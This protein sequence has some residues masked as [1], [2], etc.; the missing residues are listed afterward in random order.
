MQVC[1]LRK[2]FAVA[3]FTFA[4]LP[5]FSQAT[6]A[7]KHLFF[8]VQ[9]PKDHAPA[10]GRLL[11]FIENADMARKEAGPDGKVTEVETSPFHTEGA[12]VAAREVSYLAP[13][14]AVDIDTDDTVFP[15]GFSKLPAGDYVVQVLLDVNH[16]FDYNGRN[17]GD[18]FS[19]VANIHMDASMTDGPTL[20]LSQ[21]I[22][23]QVPWTLH[24]PANLPPAVQE[25]V[26]AAQKRLDAARANTELIEFLSPSL[27]AFW[28]RNTY[29]RA[30]VVLPPGYKEHPAEKFP[31]VYFTHGFSGSLNGLLGYVSSVDDF[32]QHKQMPPMLWVLLD[33]SSPTGTHEFAD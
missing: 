18:L 19:D 3:V 5:L 7:S 25:R 6:S 15:T 32:M 31:T 20:T 9:L 16:T 26:A 24:V 12:S 13:G 1:T 22:P 2:A 8:H 28:G 27:T 21:T 14:T 10:S 11:V 30:W 4:A 17:P 23:P 29:I 33:E